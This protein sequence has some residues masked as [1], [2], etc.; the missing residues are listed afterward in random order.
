[1]GLRQER[2]ADEIRDIIAQLFSGGQLSDPRLASVCI[3]AVKL[4]GDL[5]IASIYFRT[6]TDTVALPDVQRG[7]E[8]V[9]GLLKRKL[10]AALDIRRMPELRFFFDES[11]E[12]G[13][14]IESLIDKIKS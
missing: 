3:T 7:L 8:S 6:Y 11:I 1:M 2:L 12:R 5:Q 10:S 9:S 4:S 14:K 13:N